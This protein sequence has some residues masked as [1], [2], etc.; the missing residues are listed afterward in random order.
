MLLFK[1][2]RLVAQINGMPFDEYIPECQIQNGVRCT[3]QIVGN[4]SLVQT[5]H[6]FDSEGFYKT[7][8]DIFI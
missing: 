5:A 6:T 7:I 1:I 3:S 2:H 4:E 8:N